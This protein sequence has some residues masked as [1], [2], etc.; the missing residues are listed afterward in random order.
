M[1]KKI[2]LVTILVTLLLHTTVDCFVAKSGSNT[3]WIGDIKGTPMENIAL[4][5]K[6]II[7]KMHY[8][9]PDYQFYWPGCPRYYDR[10]K[11]SL[12]CMDISTGKVLWIKYFTEVQFIKDIVCDEDYLCVNIEVNKTNG[13]ESTIETTIACYGIKDGG[14]AWSKK[15]ISVSKEGVLV[16][17]SFTL[18]NNGKLYFHN[19]DAICLDLRSGEE[20]WRTRIVDHVEYEFEEPFFIRGDKIFFIGTRG[21]T[22]MEGSKVL[23]KV[24]NEKFFVAYCYYM[25]MCSGLICDY[26]KSI[27]SSNHFF[28]VSGNDLVVF[29]NGQCDSGE[30]ET[31][32]SP[33]YIVVDLDT[34]IIKQQSV[35]L[36]GDKA[37]PL[38]GF[39]YFDDF[40]LF[41]KHIVINDYYAKLYCFDF[42]SGKF[43]WKIVQQKK[44]KDPKLIVLGS[45]K[46]FVVAADIASKDKHYVKGF[47]LKTGNEV[48]KLELDI[49]KYQNIIL[50]G[51]VLY[52][53]GDKKIQ[54]YDLN[55]LDVSKKI[56]YDMVNSVRRQDGKTIPLDSPI[57]IVNNR[58]FICVSDFLGPLNGR[59]EF[60]DK[61]GRITA[62]LGDNNVEI[63][64]NKPDA[65]VNGKEKQI[66]P[67]NPRVVPFANKDGF[68]MVPLRFLAEN[69]GCTVKWIAET[70]TIIVTYQP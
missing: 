37:D 41:E 26:G 6:C 39:D 32:F 27:T 20:I 51:T 63:W 69:L 70:K 31:R 19:N 64:L 29:G 35:G 62:A 36:A 5:S 47:S 8:Y 30:G 40:F 11:K 45:Y 1:I 54:K 22:C 49:K 17:P 3:A 55:D 2:L 28:S 44:Q 43:L 65:I 13:W 56:E 50:E 68:I 34:G 7:F 9:P 15:I 52:A 42:P 67:H 12:T 60:E 59:T 23:W 48:W 14:E 46:N 33:C 4:N 53:F 18:I 58:V 38:I 24:K 57:Y 10:V 16:M 21:I 61:E 25:D 66:D